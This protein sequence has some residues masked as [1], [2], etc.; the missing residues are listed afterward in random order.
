LPAGVRWLPNR[1]P[2]DDRFL[3]SRLCKRFFGEDALCDDPIRLDDVPDLGKM[4]SAKTE[5]LRDQATASTEGF[6]RDE[7]HDPHHVAI[8]RSWPERKGRWQVLPPGFAKEQ[9]EKKSQAEADRRRAGL[10]TQ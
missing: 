1:P 5:L 8:E 4:L 6:G 10:E 3:V 9:A 7:L 2:N